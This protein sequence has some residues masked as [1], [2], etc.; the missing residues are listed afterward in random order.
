MNFTAAI[1][2]GLDNQQLVGQPRAKFVTRVAEAIFC[3]KSYP[4]KEEY[5]N[6]AQEIIKK[7]DFLGKQVGVVSHYISEVESVL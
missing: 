5:R 7:Y 6:V 1:Q 2:S 3:F 4:T